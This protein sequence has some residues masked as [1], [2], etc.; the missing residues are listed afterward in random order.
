VEKVSGR[1]KGNRRKEGKRGRGGGGG[2]GRERGRE[3]ESS[4][5]W[6]VN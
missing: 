6:L 3:R 1:E 2:G 5:E 4:G